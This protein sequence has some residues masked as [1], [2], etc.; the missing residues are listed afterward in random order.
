MVKYYSLLPPL[1]EA[2]QQLSSTRFF[3]RFRK[4]RGRVENNSSN[5]FRL[6]WIF[7]YAIWLCLCSFCVS[8]IFKQGA[9]LDKTY[10][11]LAWSNQLLRWAGILLTEHQSTAHPAHQL[12]EHY[13]MYIPQS[14][15]YSPSHIIEILTDLRPH[16]PT[17]PSILNDH[18]GTLPNYWS[19]K[20][21][22]HFLNYIP[23]NIVSDHCPWS[24]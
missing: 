14:F 3:S 12:Y 17:C 24:S 10:V 9:H 19:C 1:P 21:V 15:V 8:V 23:K 7:S 5:H 20:H 22:F 18:L 2:L 4:W 13:C 16:D 6:L 11:P